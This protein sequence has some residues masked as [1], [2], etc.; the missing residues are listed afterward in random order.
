M[1]KIFT[2]FFAILI[3]FNFTSQI[4]HTVN[5]GN[6]YYNPN[7]ITIDV[8]DT[9]HWINDNG[10]HNVNFSTNTITGSSFNNPESF[11]STP[12]SNQDMYSH[13]FTIPGQYLYDCSVGSHA[14]NGMTGEVIVQTPFG[15]TENHVHSI[16]DETFRF[17]FSENLLIQFNSFKVL[18]NGVVNLIG[19]DG[20]ILLNQVISI[21]EGANSF[22]FSVKNISSNSILFLSIAIDGNQITKKISSIK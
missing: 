21:K 15:S 8:G 22:S 11:I 1:K 19:L 18:N 16:I 17:S 5:S 20:K 14:A 4:S 13:V 2:L 6:F 9:V 12:T 10:F 7:S 3:A